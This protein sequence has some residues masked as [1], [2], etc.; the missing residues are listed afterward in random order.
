MLCTL[1]L[2]STRKKNQNGVATDCE[3]KCDAM[4]I[5]FDRIHDTC[6]TDKQTDRQTDRQ[7]VT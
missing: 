4:F 6:Q 3:K 7:M 1:L 2:L 5:R